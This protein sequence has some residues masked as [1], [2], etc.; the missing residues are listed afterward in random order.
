MYS[1]GR[2]GEPEKDELIVVGSDGLFDFLDPDEI[3]SIARAAGNPTVAAAAL[4][5]MVRYRALQEAGVT[6]RQ[7]WEQICGTG[8]RGSRTKRSKKTGP[9]DLGGTPYW[10]L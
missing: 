8:Y 7:Y 6:E 9:P 3:A 5:G 4:T 1:C 10:T 2:I